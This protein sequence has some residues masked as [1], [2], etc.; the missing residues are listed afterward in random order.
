MIVRWSRQW[1]GLTWW[2]LRLTT[3]AALIVDAYVH[4]RLIDR[5]DP[6]Q[7]GAVISQGE[8]F[9]LE[10]ALSAITAIALILV[11]RRAVW[12]FALLVAA[13]ALGGVLL[14][15]YFDPGGLGPLPDMHEPIWYPQK[16]LTAV[17]ES[18][19]VVTAFLGYLMTPSMSRR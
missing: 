5:Y 19:A 3:A 15:R 14:Y 12:V 17:A 8:L 16:S 13:S 7:G 10:V 6:N 2:L 4:A 9:R 11:P 18:A 1:T